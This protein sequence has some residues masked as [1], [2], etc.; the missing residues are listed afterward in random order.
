M[1]AQQERISILSSFFRDASHEFK[2]PLSIINTSIYILGKTEDKLTRQQHS[3]LIQQQVRDISDLVET[4]VLMSRLDSRTELTFSPLNINSIMR[5]TYV[6]TCDSY[7]HREHDIQLI[8]DDELPLILGHANYILQAIG[9]LVDNAMR[10]S[11][12]GDAVYLRTY[13]NNA[14]VVV[15]IEDEGIGIPNNKLSEIFKRF[16]RGDEAHST[17]GF[18]LGLPIAQRI[19]Q[20]HGGEVTVESVYDHGSVFRMVF[21][22]IKVLSE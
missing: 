19:A 3:N 12:L 17:R 16:Y 18:G 8:L 13:H 11:N 22:K 15:E 2:T 14:Y 20:R 5:Q 21:P 9:N 10:Y 4:L 1:L 7:P 6:S